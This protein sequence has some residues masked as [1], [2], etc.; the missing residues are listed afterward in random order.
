M[1]DMVR[2]Y[3]GFARMTVRGE[4]MHR[5]SFI[6]GR[7][8]QFLSYGSTFLAT[9]IMISNF[10]VIGGWTAAKVLYMFGYNL[11]AYALAACVFYNP[12]R[13]LESKVRSGELDLSLTKPVHPMTHE[14]LMGFNPG[15]INHVLLSLLTMILTARDAGFAYTPLNVMLWLVMLAGSVMIHGAMLLLSSAG[16]FIFIRHN[17]YSM[18]IGIGKEFVKYPITIYPK[19]IQVILTFVLPFAFI[20]F[21]PVSLLLGDDGLTSF[22][23][24]VA[25]FTP[26]VG[27][28]VFALGIAVWNRCLKHYQSSGN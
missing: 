19:A 21:Y 25:Y 7:V 1:L 23:H 8:G 20:S 26:V 12:S 18:V 5:A 4:M 2:L 11:L 15:Y 27:G 3:L 16:S 28:I 17:P 10:N 14:L 13:G 24:V 22:S 9:Y 6:A